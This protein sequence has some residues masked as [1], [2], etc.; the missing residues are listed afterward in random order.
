MP[1][2]GLSA[3][4]VNSGRGCKVA[5]SWIIVEFPIINELVIRDSKKAVTLT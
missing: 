5:G 1:V 3:A 2:L 4:T